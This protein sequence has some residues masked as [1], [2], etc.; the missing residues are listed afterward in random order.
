MFKHIISARHFFKDPLLTSNWKYLYTLM[1]TD[2]RWP[3]YGQFHSF[4][5]SKKS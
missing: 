5:K 4:E 1:L 2:S 3:D